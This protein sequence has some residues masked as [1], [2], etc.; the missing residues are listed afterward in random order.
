IPVTEELV[1]RLTRLGCQPMMRSSIRPLIQSELSRDASHLIQFPEDEDIMDLA[2]A[3]LV[4]GGDG[5]IL[6]IADQASRH[7][8]PVLGINCGTI[9]FMS[10]I[11]PNELRL[12]ERLV[13]KQYT[14]DSRIMLDVAVEDADGNTGYSGTVL[15]EAVVSKGYANKVIELSVFVD[16]Q[17]TFGFGGDGV[18]VCTPT[19]STAYSLAAG[20]PIL[21]PSSA[22]FAVTPICPHSLTI[23]SFVVSADSEITIIPHYRNHFIY[24]SA[25]GFDPFEMKQGDQV[26]IRKSQRSFSLLRLK[27]KGFYENIGKK[28]TNVRVGR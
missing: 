15:N 11:E 18:I 6:K 1:M 16:G 25:D 4:V 23:K 14:V 22:C 20:G 2:D 26:R 5:T 19:G 28:L 21:A 24:L 17:E 7:G 27:G 13:N 12:V 10:E 3:I 9:G 8:K